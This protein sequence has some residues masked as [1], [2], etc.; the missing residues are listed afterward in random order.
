M[1]QF[2]QYPNIPNAA[3]N[4][5]INKNNKRYGGNAILSGSGVM[6]AKYYPSVGS[7]MFSMARQV[8]KKDGGGGV[9][10]Y[11][12]SDYIQLKRLNAIGKSSN[13]SNPPTANSFSTGNNVNKNVVNHRKKFVR[14]GGS[15]A[16]A[17]KGYVGN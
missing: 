2:K 13:P 5:S 6:P 4:Y 8:W 3:V 9:N 16:P 15:V 12:S 10:T 17:K 1:S 14:S 11:Q 7:S